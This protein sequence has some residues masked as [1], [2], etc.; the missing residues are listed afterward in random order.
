MWSGRGDG[1]A[2][3]GTMPRVPHRSRL[4]L[5]ILLSGAGTL[6]LS[7]VPGWLVNDRILLGEGPRELVAHF[8]AWQSQA[9]PVLAAAVVVEVAVGVGAALEV[10]GM[11]AARRAAGLIAVLAAI[12]L[13]LALAGLWPVSQ[14]GHASGVT[15]T[16]GWPLAIAI[17]LAGAAL[18]G[19]LLLTA[20]RRALLA[21]VAGIVL[22]T[23]LAG[24]GARQVGLNLA[25]GTGQH[26]S[27]GTYTRAGTDG[28][29]I[30]Q[31]TMRS[32][33]Y[34]VDGRWSGAFE[35]SGNVVILT[36]DPACPQARG[37]YHV[38]AAG[39]SGQIRWEKI[40]DLC[41]GGERARDL[42]AGTWQRGS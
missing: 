16:P 28:A 41:A 12:G 14:S 18:S 9:V 7:F 15:I 36:G 11:V 13:G 4:A 6:G 39:S 21:G 23:T 33:R 30:E 25:E 37:S 22:V 5:G 26:W 35:A 10:A 31:L 40:V 1:S 32:G 34:S 42:E 19:T 17:V 29:A 8:S 3:I 2:S 27:E 24:A 38:Q 20:P